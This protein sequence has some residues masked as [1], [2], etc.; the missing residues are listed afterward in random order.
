M[1]EIL[2]TAWSQVVG[3]WQELLNDHQSELEVG[4]YDVWQQKSRV[5]D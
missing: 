3:D 2:E 1:G 4:A 5:E